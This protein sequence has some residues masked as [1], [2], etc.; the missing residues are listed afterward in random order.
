MSWAMTSMNWLV[1]RRN[2]YLMGLWITNNFWTK[3][4][5]DSVNGR[6]AYHEEWPLRL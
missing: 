6:Y 5:S 1:A 3:W 4:Q 2:V